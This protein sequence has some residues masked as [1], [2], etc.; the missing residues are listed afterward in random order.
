MNH[1][2]F[3]P[4]YIDLINEDIEG[5]YKFPF[6]LFCHRI[7]ERTFKINGYYFPVCA[8]CTGIYISG[9]CFFL[10]VSMLSITYNINLISLSIIL[11]IPMILD[12]I[13]Q[14]FG[15]R[16]SDNKVRFCT[17]LLAGVGLGILAKAIKFILIT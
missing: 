6:Y 3:N 16:N 9:L 14:L 17:G 7:P 13:T 15:K 10:L 8:R 5:A 2:K 4:V 1:T 12:G 11:I